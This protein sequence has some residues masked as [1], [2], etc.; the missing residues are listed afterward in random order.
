MF[1][2]LRNTN[3]FGRFFAN[4]YLHHSSYRINN[5][6]YKHLRLYNDEFIFYM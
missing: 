2:I 6:F 1:G 3:M 4:N 5:N